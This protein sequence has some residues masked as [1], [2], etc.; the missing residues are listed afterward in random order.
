MITANS[1]RPTRI[2]TRGDQ[3]LNLPT[4]EPGKL[5]ADDFESK[6]REPWRLLDK[7][8]R[9]KPT[10]SERVY[11]VMLAVVLGIVGALLAVYFLSKP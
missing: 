8:S 7:P 10:P 9:A 11:G 4:I 1:T 2:D 5:T 6:L 3:N